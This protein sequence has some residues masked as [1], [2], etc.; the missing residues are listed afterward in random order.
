MKT[1]KR[2][3]EGEGG[4]GGEGEGE[5]EQSPPTVAEGVVPQSPPTVAV[6]PPSSRSSSRSCSRRKFPGTLRVI[7]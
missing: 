5:G 3:G 7:K 4:G 2:E 6:D 1:K